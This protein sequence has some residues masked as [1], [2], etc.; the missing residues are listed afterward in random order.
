MELWTEARALKASLRGEAI[1]HQVTVSSEELSRT[2]S[3][4]DFSVECFLDFSE[5]GQEEKLVS[6]TSSQEEQEQDCCIYSSQPCIFDQLPSLP[7]EYVEELEW[8]SRVVDDCSSPEVSLLLT[9]THKI[10]PNFS[11]SIPVKPRTKRSRN[12][13]TGDRVWPLVSKNQHANG[14]HGRKEKKE[15]AVGFQRRCSHCGTNNTPQWRTGPVGPKTLCNACGVRFKSGR[16][17]PEYRPADSPTFSSE[18]H[19]NLHRKVLELRKSKVLVEETGE[20]TTKSD[21]VKFASN[22]VDRT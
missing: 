1:K 5:E 10:K 7:D 18:I 3:A 20:A 4:E 11:S 21:Q 19:S 2:S 12:S 13:L 9:Q 14:E 15:I 16:L 8:V 17:C 6:V 22:A